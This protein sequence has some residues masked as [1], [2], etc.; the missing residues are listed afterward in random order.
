V[1]QQCLDVHGGK[2]IQRVYV[3]GQCDVY[4]TALRKIVVMLCSAARHT[5]SD[6]VSYQE[7][8]CPNSYQLD[9]QLYF[10]RGF[11]V[12]SRGWHTARRA[13]RVVVALGD[14]VPL[15]VGVLYCCC[16]VSAPADT[17]MPSA[18]TCMP[19][20]LHTNTHSFREIK[21]RTPAR[22]ACTKTPDDPEL[23]QEGF[24]IDRIFVGSRRPCYLAVVA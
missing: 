3:A 22:G 19:K 15:P 10:V 5:H 18:I 9:Q 11:R 23:L 17:D 21:A 1:H 4:P 13:K 16:F 2:Q 20:M 24:N 14:R 6:T 8:A 7:F 12:Q